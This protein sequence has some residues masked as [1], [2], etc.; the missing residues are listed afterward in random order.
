LFGEEAKLIPV[1]EH[2][3]DSI[4]GIVPLELYMQTNQQKYL[5]LGKSFA[6]KQWEDPL[7]DGLTKQTRFWIDDMYMI[8]MVQLQTLR[9]THDAKY[10]DRGLGNGRLPRQAATAQR[11]LLSRA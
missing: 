2:V 9:A 3:D 10:L 1:P 6:D 4:F 11:S 5:D 7:S 8:T